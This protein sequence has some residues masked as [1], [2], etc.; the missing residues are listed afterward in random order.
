M[1]NDGCL[2]VPRRRSLGRLQLVKRRRR[3]ECRAAWKKRNPAAIELRGF[4]LLYGPLSEE[5]G[6]RFR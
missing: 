2:M 3:G 6:V 4:V 1:G 5:P